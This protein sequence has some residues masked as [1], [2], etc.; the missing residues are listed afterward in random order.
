MYAVSHSSDPLPYMSI[1]LYYIVQNKKSK[2]NARNSNLYD[3]FDN[4]ATAQLL[5]SKILSQLTLGL[6]IVVI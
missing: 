3:Y 4:H 6:D 5:E 1:T 2:S